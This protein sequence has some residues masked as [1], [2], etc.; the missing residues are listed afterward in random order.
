MNKLLTG[1]R[2]LLR[3]NWQKRID[4]IRIIYLIIKISFM[5]RFIPLRYYHKKYLSGEQSHIVDLQFYRENIYLIKRILR[6]V[7]WHVSCLIESLIIKDYICKNGILLPIS[8]GVRITKGFEAHA[9]CFGGKENG[10][11][12]IN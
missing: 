10:F 2:F 7:P 1:I 11:V 6:N 5:V 3:A 9:W 4:I 12:K 8:L